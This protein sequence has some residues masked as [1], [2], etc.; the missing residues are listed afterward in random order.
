MVRYGARIRKRRAD[1]AGLHGQSA[2]GGQPGRPVFV[3][4]LEGLFDQHTPKTGTVDEEIA[5]DPFARLQ[6]ERRDKPAL[7]ILLDFLDQAFNPFDALGLAES[8]QESGIE[9]GIEM[10]GV[11]DVG[12]FG[13]V[14][15][16]GLGGLKFVA[17][18]IQFIPDAALLRI[19]PDI[20]EL[21]HPVRLAD[22]AEGVDVAVALAAPIL[23]CDSELEGRLGGAHELALIDPHQMVEGPVRRD[24]RLAYSDRADGIG[25]H[26]GDVEQGAEQA[27]KRRRCDPARRAAPGN[28]NSPDV[29]RFQWNPR[30]FLWFSAI[31]LV[32]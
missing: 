31:E 3:T 2:V 25:F 27:G 19:H 5:F 7:A 32:Q 29:L 8:P 1:R 9:A 10:I 6:F 13:R 18:G 20:V 21:P 28:D 15:S 23:E 12:L 4:G 30:F 24:G 11:I 17:I 26:E 16:P 22:L 14:E